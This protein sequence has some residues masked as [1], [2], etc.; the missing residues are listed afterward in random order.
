[1]FKYIQSSKHV[2]I[3]SQQQKHYQEVWNLLKINNKDC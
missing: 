3:Q 2:P 1:M